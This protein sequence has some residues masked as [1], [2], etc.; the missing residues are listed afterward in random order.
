MTNFVSSIPHPFNLPLLCII[1]KQMP[2]IFQ[3]A[4]LK[5]KDSLKTENQTPYINY[6]SRQCSKF[7]LS[8]K[9]YDFVFTVFIMNWNLVEVHI[10]N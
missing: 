2:D 9:C 6:P 8:H 1:L 3:Y 4:P 10:C 7:Q 5:D